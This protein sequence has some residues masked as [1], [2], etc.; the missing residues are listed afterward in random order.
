MSNITRQTDRP[1][2]A[3]IEKPRDAG[4][5]VVGF[6]DKLAPRSVQHTG[7]YTDDDGQMETLRGI[8]F[9]LP[10]SRGLIAGYADPHN[11]G[12]AFVEL[13]LTDKDDETGAAHAAD[14]IAELAAEEERDYQRAWRAGQRYRDLE[15]EISIMR[16]ACLQLIHESKK[17][18]ASIT[19]TDFEALKDAIRERI[20]HY[21]D[22]IQSA[23]DD[24]KNL[25]SDYG[26]EAAFNDA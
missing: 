7:W 9:R 18:C 2:Y 15:D 25:K 19:T 8:V 12:A 20:E 11:D 13:R 14:R 22:N 5:R 16:K 10:H 17:L 26:H 23:R 4:L 6:A 24:R 1:N 21:R 3:W